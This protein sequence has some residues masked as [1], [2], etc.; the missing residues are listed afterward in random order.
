[1]KV[2]VI[3]L[4]YVGCVSAA[5]LAKDNH[6]VI[7]VDINAKKLGQLRVGKSPI[8]ESGLDSLIKSGVESERLAVTSKTREAIKNSE[9]SL[10]CVG[11]PSRDNGSLNLDFVRTV[12]KEIGSALQNHQDYHTVIVRSTVLPGTVRNELLPILESESG[13][14]AGKDFGLCMNPEF[15]REGTAIE[16]YYNP[17]VMVIGQF[18]ERSG[19]AVEELYR[20]IDAKVIRSDLETAETVKYANNAFHALKVTFANE[21]GNFA[22]AHGVDGR[23][24]MDILCSDERLNISPSYLKPGFAFGGSCLPKD[25][26]A[27]MHQAKLSDL[28]SPLLESILSSNEEQ[29]RRGI[30]LVE[31]TNQKKVAVMG[32]SFKAGTDDV[33]ESPT[34]AL[35]ETLVGKGYQVKLY[36]ETIRVGELIGANK[37]FLYS[38]IP[39]IT[40]L[41]ANSMDEALNDSEVIVLANNSPGF[42]GLIEKIAPEQT[43]IDLVGHHKINGNLRG[44]YEGI[45]W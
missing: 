16:D 25:M 31:E 33:R 6:E 1:M 18:N 24:I 23:T 27:M 43:L 13:K 37:A 8:V 44:K 35:I 2:S 45:C 41:L 3:G 17:A 9:A 34:I 12:T 30:R 4:G 29:I 38:E 15:L 11:T 40:S 32:L 36:D 10:I 14:V 39:H 26:R 7:G 28:D 21:I 22:K 19:D 42:A 20:N 5:C